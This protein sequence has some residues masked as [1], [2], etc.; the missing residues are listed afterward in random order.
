LV[1]IA[2]KITPLDHESLAINVHK[3]NLRYYVDVAIHFTTIN[4]GTPIDTSNLDGN[5]NETTI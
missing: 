1:N 2:T 3:I 5:I 4:Y